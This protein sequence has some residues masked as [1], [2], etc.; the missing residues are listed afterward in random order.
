MGRRASLVIALFPWGDVVEEFLDPIGLRLKDFVEQMTGGWL[1]GYV[2]ALQLAGHRPVIVCASEHASQIECHYHAGTGAPIW[3]V[4]GARARQGHSAA[5]HSLRRWSATPLPAFREVLARSQCDA[6]LVQEYEYTRFDALAW[7]AVRNRIPLYATFQG[8]DRTLSWIEAIARQ[9]SLRACSG[10]I[11]ASA[12]ERERLAK[13]YP[14][15]A[16]KV[17]NIANPID[18]SEWTAIERQQARQDLCLARGNF[19]VV[20]HG[21]I[22]VRRKGLDVLLK[23]WSFFSGDASSELVIIG[24]GQDRDV[25]ARLLREAALP[26]V[27][28]LCDYT[29]DRSL[30]RRW[31]SAAD[32]YVT[33][34]R[35]EGMPVAPLEA[36]ACGLPIVATDAQGLPDILADGEASGGLIVR[37][38]E[39]AE[40]A[41]ALKK[42]KDDPTMRDR[43]GQAARKRIEGSFSLGAVAGA[44][45]RL[46]TAR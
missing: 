43:L 26:N 12:A 24:S 3:V 20:N 6:I 13:A 44:L 11:V 42:L 23:A 2:S 16:L 15:I 34:S 38:D 4:P 25:F 33:A 5:G 9:A 46:L 7:L 8:G 35:T 39:S 32:A 1:F 19:V 17:A 21:R 31:L 36:M 28:W 30:I 37:R 41:H 14:R 27:R 22:D 10:L 29:T 40:I 18:S 45:D